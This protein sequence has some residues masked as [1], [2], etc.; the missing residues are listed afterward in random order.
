MKKVNPTFIL[1][2]ILA[3]ISL[4][5]ILQNNQQEFWR[6]IFAGIGFITFLTFSLLVFKKNKAKKKVKFN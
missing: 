5:I 2:I 4:L 1:N 3:S 6:S